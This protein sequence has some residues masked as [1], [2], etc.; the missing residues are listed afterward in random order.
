MR[1]IQSSCNHKNTTV[2]ISEATCTKDGSSVTACSTCGLTSGEPL[3][4]NAYLE[5]C[6]FYPSYCKIKIKTATYIYSEPRSAKSTN[7]SVELEAA[8]LNTEYKV[9]GLYKNTGGNLWY[10]VKTSTGRDGYIYSGRTTYVKKLYSDIKISDCVVPTE[11]KEGEI[12]TVSG[13]ITSTYNK[14]KK[15]RVYVYSG[16]DTAGDKV[17]ASTDTITNNSYV[18]NDSKIDNAIYFDS[19]EPG[20]Y[21]YVISATYSNYYAKTTKELGVYN[22][23]RTVKKV[24]FVV[25]P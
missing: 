7:T 10:Q 20:N 4:N 24:N 12:F 3:V 13:T 8:P 25:V 22:S 19:L 16:L 11:H 1:Q 21:T 15:A 23:S 14:L 17:L 9:I 2:V 6:T 18:L 5:K